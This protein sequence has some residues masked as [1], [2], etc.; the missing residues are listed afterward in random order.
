M[1]TP[2]TSSTSPDRN[3]A[4]AGPPS[5]G[6]PAHPSLS[7]THYLE[8]DVDIPTARNTL[9]RWLDANAPHLDSIR[10]YEIVLAANEMF[11]NAFEHGSGGGCLFDM[12]RI[13]DM[14]TLT[15]TNNIDASAE[16]TD[17]SGRDVDLADPDAWTMP[18]INGRSGRGLAIVK[19]VADEVTTNVTPRTVAVAATFD[20]RNRTSAT[21][22]AEATLAL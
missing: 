16:K 8:T 7:K 3:G 19:S 21:G 9:S 22:A 20:L 2:Q 6:A 18:S 15:I 5:A 14:L 1:R 13:A 11:C 17:E 10:S 12:R 4:A